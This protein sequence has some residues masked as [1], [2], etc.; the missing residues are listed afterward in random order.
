MS[1]GA[2]QPVSMSI[3]GDR[4]VCDFARI[5]RLLSVPLTLLISVA[6]DPLD[7]VA[8]AAA[9]TDDAAQSEAVS[10]DAQ[11]LYQQA[12]QAE[13][14]GN[15]TQARTLLERAAKTGHARSLYQ[16]GFLK[17]DGLGGP[18]DVL[19]ARDHFRA[20]A[21]AGLS[22]ALVP[23]M[24][25][26]DDFDDEEAAPNTVLA[27]HALLELSQRDLGM[28]G[29]TIQFWSNPLKRQI[30][31][32]LRDAGYYSGAIDGLIGQGSLNGLRRFARSSSAL[33]DIDRPRFSTVR[34]QTDGVSV[35]AGPVV[36]FDKV[37][38]LRDARIAVLGLDVMPIDDGR[39]AV[40]HEG[41]LLI[42]WHLN[43]EP[44]QFVLLGKPKSE[45]FSFGAQKS[46]FRAEHL[47]SCMSEPQ[48]VTVARPA[49][50]PALVRQGVPIQP[51]QVGEAPM[52]DVRKPR[53]SA[54][55]ELMPALCET[56]L[57]EIKLLFEP[58]SA[59]IAT[60]P[61]GEGEASASSVSVQPDMVITN[62][63][64]PVL[65]L[66]AIEISR[67]LSLRLSANQVVGINP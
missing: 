55:P 47:A 66:T 65:A 30:Q 35:D 33:P 46:A 12:Q 4:M 58:A 34:F 15:Y 54:Q 59:P 2:S 36:S 16:L 23:L 27:S 50:A 21:D 52:Q 51:R 62:S 53:D 18:R 67:P 61:A 38:S 48:R 1:A 10:V 49:T 57:A 13:W 3:E 44:D 11:A 41:R 20:S 26:Y 6:G 22:L 31:K 17:M 5:G 45:P 63:V 42:E 25:A 7:L 8:T 40:S 19:A 28:A 39:Y 60:Q 9:S 32:D 37:T 14:S 24:Y 64:P 29:D 56:H 43:E